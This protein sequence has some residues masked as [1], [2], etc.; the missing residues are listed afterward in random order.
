MG[1]FKNRKLFFHTNKYQR[2]IIRLALLPSLAFCI[3]ISVFCLRFRFE[4]VD[5]ML[6]G[7]RSLSLHII[8]KW[9]VI[10]MIGLWVFFVFILCQTFKISLDLVGPFE[11]IN[12]DLDLTIK[13]EI[14]QHLKARDADTLAKELLQR[15]NVLIDNLPMPKAPLRIR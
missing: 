12:K 10:I 1:D 13:G 8:D 3:M 14:R 5:M 15:V 6:Y 2:Q 4:V 11:R 7:T 9:L